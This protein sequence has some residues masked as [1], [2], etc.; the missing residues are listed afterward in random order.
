[1]VVAVNLAV[2]LIVAV[3]GPESGRTYGT[4][5]VIDMVFAIEGCHIRAS[6]CPP[7]VVAKEIQSS[8]IVSFAKRILAFA[9]LIIHW[10]EF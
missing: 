4:G 8:E 1:M 2:V 10:E 9:I 3:A 5:E 6:E 7:T